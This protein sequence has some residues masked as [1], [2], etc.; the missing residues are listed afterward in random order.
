M[1]PT[2]ILTQFANCGETAGGLLNIP[3]WYK[4]LNCNPPGSANVQFNHVNDVWPI[5]TAI[6][7]IVLYIGGIS[8]IFFFIYGGIQFATSQG[9]PD[10]V[11]QA[12]QTMIYAAVGLVL[13]IIAT[14]LVNYIGGL[15]LD[16]G[17]DF[18]TTPTETS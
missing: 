2:K 1:L 7:E 3:T 13:A 4:Y 14:V 8:A 17:A 6:I 5:L 12:R 9:Q 15:F 16:S 18:D 10:K 11:A